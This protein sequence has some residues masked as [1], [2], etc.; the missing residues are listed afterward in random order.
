MS[1]LP[2]SHFFTES[3]GPRLSHSN[4]R[5][6]LILRRNAVV[7]PF[8]PVESR[9]IWYAILLF[10]YRDDEQVTDEVWSSARSVVL[11]LLRNEKH[12]GQL[13]LDADSQSVLRQYL[14]VFGA[15]ADSERSQWVLEVA[16]TIFNLQ[17]IEASV[18]STG[19][20]ESI[21]EWR[22][23]CEGLRSKI[24]TDMQR[25][26]LQ[27]EVDAQVDRIRAARD[28]AVAS[29]MRRA[30]WDTLETEVGEGRLERLY[31][32]L[33]ELRHQL[34]SIRAH[35]EDIVDVDY[36]RQR[37]ESHTADAAW[38]TSAGGEVLDFLR[39][40]DSADMQSVYEKISLSLRQGEEHVGLARALRCVLE[41]LCPLAA[42]LYH[43]K[44]YWA[45]VFESV[46]K[47]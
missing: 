15:W 3:L 39:A 7:S 38:I 22:P 4:A 29:I 28:D 41:V 11:E 45:S 37:I 44:Q 8:S 34:Q 13:L 12:S 30:F 42:S 26:G 33:H 47:K 23:L 18:A 27:T 5:S 35:D 21:A 32:Q 46:L 31:A 9:R 2:L 16:G 24:R 43:R 14:S 6:Q 25:A 10:M 1:V 19:S 36:I 17:Q 40:H 20:A